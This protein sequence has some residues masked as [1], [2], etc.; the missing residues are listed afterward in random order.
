M[1]DTNWTDLA[2]ERER[3]QVLVKAVMNV[4]VL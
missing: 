2:Q 3:W 4:R 1:G